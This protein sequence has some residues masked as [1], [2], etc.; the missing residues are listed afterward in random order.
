MNAAWVHVEVNADN[1]NPCRQACCWL[2][3]WFDSDEN[4]VEC[5]GCEFWIHDSCDMA[6]KQA[7]EAAGGNEEEEVRNAAPQALSPLHWS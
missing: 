4:M 1:R 2:Q 6:A 7:L 5:D 3:V